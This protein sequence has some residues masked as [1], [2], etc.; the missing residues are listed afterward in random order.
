M[1]SVTLKGAE[2]EEKCWVPSWW[3]RPG[4]HLRRMAG[5]IAAILLATGGVPAAAKGRLALVLA[6]EDYEAMP[7]SPIGTKRAAGVTEALKALGFEVIVAANPTNATARAGLADLSHKVQEADLALVVLVGHTTSTAGQTFFLP[8]NVDIGAATDLLSRG[9]SVTNVA[10]IVGKAKA[11]AVLVLMSVPTF[12]TPVEGTDPRPQLTGNVPKSVVVAF[13]SSSKV[14]VSRVDA[15]SG[16]DLEALTKI[17]QKPGATLADVVSAVSA[18]GGMAVGT[19]A[20]L[21]LDAPAPAPVA[22]TAPA[23]SA[24][25][26]QKAAEAEQKLKAEQAARMTAEQRAAEERAKSSSAEKE[27]AAAQESARQARL[28]A[29]K[30]KVEAERMQAEADR[31]RSVAEA[32]KARLLIQAEKDKQKLQQEQAETVQ[33]LTA[34][35]KVN[36]PSTPLDEKLLGQRQRTG[37]QEKLRA[38]SLYT[39]PID[40]VMGPLTREAIM[41]FQRNRGEAVTGYLTPEQFQVLLP[42]P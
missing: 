4:H 30:A 34:L 19:P 1:T 5:P 29:E 37:I 14:P 15:V 35:Q 32:D 6:A 36:V 23:S 25:D 16:E 27:L 39:G 38:M 31:I 41:G 9:L 33:K 11:G 7:H 10:Q 40:A 3:K 42:Q 20:D 17:L 22:D 26:A 21:R 28:E 24:A 2:I 8:V 18:E 12:K 13:S